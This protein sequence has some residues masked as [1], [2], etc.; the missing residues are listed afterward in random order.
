MT[1][2]A[3]DLPQPDSPMRG[4]CLSGE[5]LQIDL[6][7]R[8]H[9][10]MLPD[11]ECLLEVPCRDDRLVVGCPSEADLY[12]YLGGLLSGCRSRFTGNRKVAGHRPI[13]ARGNVLR[14]NRAAG[15]LAGSAGT[16]GVEAAPARHGCRRRMP[17][18]YLGQADI[19]VPQR[20]ASLE[21]GACV[22]MVLVP[23]QGRSRSCLD[24]LPGV[25]HGD[26]VG[27]SGDHPQIVADVEGRASE[28]V[29][30]VLQHA[31]DLRLDRHIQGSGR[32][33]QDQQF[34]VVGHR[35]G[36]HHSLPHTARELARVRPAPVLRI[37][38]TD[39]T[40]EFE[41]PPVEGRPRYT[42]VVGLDGLGDL[43][44]DPKDGVQCAERIL[45]DH[46]HVLAAYFPHLPLGQRHQVLAVEDQTVDFDG[47]PRD[48]YQSEDREGSQ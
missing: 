33:V 17:S 29:P 10:H 30:D 43:V 46:R 44:I 18:G 23:E 39:Q 1:L 13:R 38:D 7:D 26:L 5:Y 32:F 21:Q 16:P 40:Q 8:S 41:H 24:D 28:L 25:H 4:E 3:V 42:P 36:C 2:A 19:P 34:R 14:N 11:L 31:K 6:V 15:F 48:L 35:D 9:F 45:E 22:V 37:R 47:G 20:R 12:R 27:D